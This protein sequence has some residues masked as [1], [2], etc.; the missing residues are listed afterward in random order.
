MTSQI[1][2]LGGCSPLGLLHEVREATRKRRQRIEKMQVQYGG[3][4]KFL[5]DFASAREHWSVIT[6]P[7]GSI[8]GQRV[9]PVDIVRLV[10]KLEEFLPEYVD[11]LH[12]AN[13]FQAGSRLEVVWGSMENPNVWKMSN[14]W[15]FRKSMA[16][17]LNKP[18]IPYIEDPNDSDNLVIS[19]ID[20][21]P[22]KL[23]HNEVKRIYK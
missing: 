1:E 8:M 20:D 10:S 16:R 22:L 2:S 6:D 7:S 9:N 14:L 21:F 13:G 23:P 12:I 3:I 18:Y 17:E 4:E 15:H 11:G 19:G 5:T